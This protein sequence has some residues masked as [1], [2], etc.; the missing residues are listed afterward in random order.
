[1]DEFESLM[2]SV[3]GELRDVQSTLDE[4]ESILGDVETMLGENRLGENDGHIRRTTATG[5]RQSTAD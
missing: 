2:E 4:V 3:D 1:M 5:T